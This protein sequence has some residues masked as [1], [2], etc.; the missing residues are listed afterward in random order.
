[1]ISPNRTATLLGL[2]LSIP[3]LLKQLADWR[4][5]R[6]QAIPADPSQG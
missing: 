1:V 5:G 4:A 6:N 2:A 3:V